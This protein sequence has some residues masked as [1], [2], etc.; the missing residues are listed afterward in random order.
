MHL[1]LECQKCEIYIYISH[2]HIHEVIT[3]KI[4]L[5]LNSCLFTYKKSWEQLVNRI[6]SPVLTTNTLPFIDFWSHLRPWVTF[7]SLSKSLKLS[8]ARIQKHAACKIGTQ[9]TKPLAGVPK[10]SQLHLCVELG[11]ANDST[12]SVPADTWYLRVLKSCGFPTSNP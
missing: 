2:T 4:K 10:R 7:N 6:W 3:C 5:L 9:P 11:A 12:P 1:P 8:W